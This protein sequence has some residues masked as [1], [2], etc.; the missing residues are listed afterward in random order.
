MARHIFINVP[1]AAIALFGL[2]RY[3]PESRDTERTKRLD[4]IGAALIAFALGG[5][6]YGFLQTAESGFTPITI[7]AIISGL[8]ALGLFI[9]A[10][11]RIAQPMI[12]LKLF[13]S[14][15]FSGTN[16]LTFL[17]YGA[18]GA[19]FLMLPLNLIQVQGYTETQASLAIL[20]QGLLLMVISRRAG[21]FASQ[22]GARLPLTVGPFLIGCGFAWLAFIGVTAGINDYWLT[23]F[24]AIVLN[25]VGLGI[26]V[27]PLTT[28]VMNAVPAGRSGIASG[29]NNAVARTGSALAVAILGAIA[30][31]SFVGAVE[32]GGSDLALIPD[33]QTALIREARN[34]GNAQVPE[35]VPIEQRDA[36]ETL[37]DQAF[38]AAF[39]SVMA[40]GAAL[41][42][43]SA[44]L[45][46][47]SLRASDPTATIAPESV[48]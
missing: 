10:E 45:G 27:A 42:F 47:I 29:V 21:A 17:L 38:I 1:I 28:A 7:A 36:I 35:L 43:G 18:L 26:T 48:L 13:R 39:R 2:I 9:V 11:T 4:L 44:A 25:G 20:P 37:Y 33:A 31:L 40:I 24:P 41:A 16:L 5:V 19:V 3:V 22:R 34:F 30:L 6:S 15:T 23:F 8:I 32:R 14:R 46:W 12:P